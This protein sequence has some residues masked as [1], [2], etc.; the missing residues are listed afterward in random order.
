LGI[1]VTTTHKRSGRSITSFD[2]A[3]VAVPEPGTLGL[4]GTGLLVAGLMFRRRQ[5]AQ[6]G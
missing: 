6:A 4:V 3:V 1:R 2:G 5:Q